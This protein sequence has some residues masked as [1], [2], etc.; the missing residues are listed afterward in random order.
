MVS[1]F[2]KF[3]TLIEKRNMPELKDYSKYSKITAH[4]K[5]ASKR[6]IKLTADSFNKPE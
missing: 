2:T 6:Q 3:Q 1:L 5:T 4:M